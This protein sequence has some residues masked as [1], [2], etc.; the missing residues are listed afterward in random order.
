M[1]LGGPKQMIR[2]Y[3]GYKMYFENSSYNCPLLKLC[4]FKNDRQLEKAI[5]REIKK[6]LE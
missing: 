5:D 6:R 1:C 3:K 2:K 4:G